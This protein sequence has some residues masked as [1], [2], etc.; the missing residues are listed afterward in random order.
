MEGCDKTMKTEF[1]YIPTNGNSEPISQNAT[2][3]VKFSD[4]VFVM[5]SFLDQFK[6]DYKIEDLEDGPIGLG[7]RIKKG[8]DQAVMRILEPKKFIEE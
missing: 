1:I 7:I 3:G 4:D 8:C 5:K 2:L 6:I